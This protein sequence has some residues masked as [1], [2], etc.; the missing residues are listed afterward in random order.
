MLTKGEEVEE[1]EPPNGEGL[2]PKRNAIFAIAQRGS[3]SFLP[4]CV[5][6]SFSLP[7]FAAN[8]KQSKPL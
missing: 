8:F 3:C 4:L 7:H 5:G 6:I 1:E 2:N